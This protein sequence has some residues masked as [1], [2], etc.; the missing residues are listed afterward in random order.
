MPLVVFE[1]VKCKF[2]MKHVISGVMNKEYSCFCPNC[3][4]KSLF[5]FV[6]EGD[7]DRDRYSRMLESDMGLAFRLGGWARVP[8]P[9]N[10]K[11]NPSHNGD[12]Q[13]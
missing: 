10:Q 1:C 4:R 9:P 2:E 11:K 7:R 6:R 3:D 5:V 13:D 8:K 12:A